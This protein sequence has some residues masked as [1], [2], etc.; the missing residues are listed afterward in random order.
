MFNK[1]IRMA[2]SNRLLVI[3][4]TAFIF[5]YG[6]LII[7]HLPVDIFPNLNRPVVTIMSESHG[8]APEDV[9]TLVTIPIETAMGGM[10]GVERIRSSS[11]IGL[12]MVFVEFAWGTDVY[13][14]R[15]L[16]SERLS[17]VQKTLPEGVHGSIGP[18]TSIMGETQLVGLSSPNDEISPIELRSFA[19]WVVR[20]RLLAI[21]GVAQVTVMGG[22]VK[23]YQVLISSEKVKYF[24]FSLEDLEH[25]LS[26]LSQNTSGGFYRDG[27]DA[28]LI[29]NIGAVEGVEDIENSMVGFHLG[30]PIL[31]KDIAEVRL[32][33][34]SVRFGDASING[35]ASVVLT[36]RKQPDTSTI[37]LTEEVNKVLEELETILPS[38]S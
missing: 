32:D 6:A 24:G 27:N 23:Q 18:I 15:Q 19:D 14:N 5:V 11:A 31:V 38:G 10:P 30:N 13:R 17:L 7:K 1:M 4:C 37:K 12:S 22:L 25:S 34:P 16:V 9:E 36:I 3:A 20:K 2:L 35:N 28:L 21:P 29:R 33:G 26:H 8:M